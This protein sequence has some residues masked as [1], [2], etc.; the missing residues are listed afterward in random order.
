M[1]KS[2]LRFEK[3]ENFTGNFLQKLQIVGM[4]NLQDPFDT[5]KRSFISAFSICMATFKMFI[6]WLKHLPLK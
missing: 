5:R 6:N 4:R 1:L 3:T 2:R